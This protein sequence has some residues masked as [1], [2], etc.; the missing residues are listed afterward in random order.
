MSSARQTAI[1]A[2]L[3]VALSEG[4]LDLGLRAY[5][6]GTGI[7]ARMLTHHFGGNDG[8]KAALVEEIEERLRQEVTIALRASPDTA[9]EIAK[10]F[11]APDRGPLRRL[12]RA[13]LR[14]ALAGDRAS[15]A[16]LAA[17]RERWRPALPSPNAELD[18]F[19]LIGGAVDAM[20]ADAIDRDP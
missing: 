15:A 5:E 1:V 4:R 9:F 6:R 13:I 20:L 2:C 3:D 7:S 10:A 12:L 17:E 19:V 11:A 8:L 14:D 18:L 16:I